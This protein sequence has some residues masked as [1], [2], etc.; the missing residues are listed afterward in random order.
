MRSIVQRLKKGKLMR[1]RHGLITAGLLI[2]L[3]TAGVQVARAVPPLPSSFYGTVKINGANVPP[4]TVVSAWIN[5]VKYAET[6][7][8]LFSG[9]TVYSLN[10]PGDDPTTPGVIE[11]GVQGETVS[12]FIGSGAALQS[13]TWQSGSNVQLNLSRSAA[14]APATITIE[15]APTQLTVGS[16]AAAVVT[17]TLRD[18]SNQPVAGVMLSGS[19]TPATL[20]VVSLPTVTN[21][22][23]QTMGS[24]TAGSVAGTGLLRVGADTLSSTV[25][26]TLNNP[27]PV[28]INLSPMTVTVNSPSFTLTVTGTNFVISTVIQWNGIPRDAIF[29]SGTRLQTLIDSAELTATGMVTVTA[30]NPAPGGGE[31]GALY[32]AIVPEKKFI[33]LPL[34][35]R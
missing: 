4:D 22:A 2:L 1:L 6:T 30:F 25:P 7:V 15:V 20:G 17:A 14:S 28:L 12:F 8:L 18:D 5:G 10:V 33:Y 21:S 31:S 24:W 9:D 29:V 11:G 27:V 16:A 23:G 34:L 32:V 19:T 35:Q 3:L 13:G 26:I